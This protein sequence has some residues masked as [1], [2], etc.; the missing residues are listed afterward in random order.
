MALARFDEVLAEM[1]LA[2]DMESHN[3]SALALKGE[4]L[5]R[6][7]DVHQAQMILEQASKLVFGDPYVEQLQAEAAATAAAPR[8]ETLDIDPELEGVEIHDEAAM[9]AGMS[10]SHDSDSNIEL[11]D[12]DLLVEATPTPVPDN[13]DDDEQTIEAPAELMARLDAGYAGPI[14]GPFQDRSP[15]CNPSNAPSVDSQMWSSSATAARDSEAG[16]ARPASVGTL[17]P[18]DESG[19]SGL[20]LTS[21]PQGP[22]HSESGQPP[23]LGPDVPRAMTADMDLIREGLSPGQPVPRPTAAPRPVSMASAAPVE[24]RRDARPNPSAKRKRKV[25]A[26]LWIVLLLISVAG[27]FVAGLRLR[28]ERLAGQIRQAKQDAETFSAGDSYLGYRKARDLY[29]RIFK[30]QDDDPS[31]GALA[32]SEAALAAEFGHSPTTGAA[33]LTSV[34]DKEGLDALAASAYL[35]IANGNHNGASENAALLTQAFADE[36]VGHYLLGRAKI[37]SDDPEAA[38]VAIDK[39]LQLGASPLIYVAQARAE[40]QRG[41]YPEA[42]AAIAKASE[43]AQANAAA[44]IWQARIL[45]QSGELP[46]NPADPDDRLQELILRS[47]SRSLEANAL[48]PAQGAWAG[49]VLAEIKLQRGDNGEARKALAEAKIGRPT[50]WLFSEMLA[51]ILIRLGENKEAREEATRAREVWPQRSKPR[52]V[53]ALVALLDGNPE[54][55]IDELE[56]F[57]GIEASADALTVRGRAN[58][59]LGKLDAAV[60]DLDRALAMRSRDSDALIA[61]AKVDL[62]RGDAKAAI[63]R[64]E[65][66]YDRSAGPDLAIAYATALRTSGKSIEARKVLEPIAGEDGTVAALIELAALERS[67]GRFEEARA[68]FQRAISIDSGSLD[69][70]LG[71]ALLDIDDGRVKSGRESLDALVAEGTENGLILVEAARARIW[72]GDSEAATELLDRTAKSSSWLNWKVA[73][74]RGR[75]LLRHQEPI[76]AISELQRAQSLRPTD[77]EARILLMEA[78]FAARNR[79]GSGRALQD[80]TKTF[81]ES[82]LR[83]MASGIHALLHEKAADA[84]NSFS[85]ARSLLIDQKASRLELA[86]VAYWLGRSYE[87]SGDL[88]QASQWLQKATKLNRSHAGAYFWL[89]HIHHQDQKPKLMAASYEQA[90][91]IDPRHNPLAWFF[92]GTYYAEAGKKVAAVKAL[93]SFLRF[94]P[95]DSGDVVVEAKTLLGQIR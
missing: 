18:D 89:G 87:F 74:E 78:H 45:L 76:E 33:L 25:P 94:Y 35:A 86:R 6:K 28:E 12:E 91:A 42:L 13:L 32:R 80:I 73:R 48:S 79:Q 44:L 14:D 82:A 84:V 90:V 4:A 57:E 8:H 26:A 63:G 55:A 72:T 29:A 2:L 38:L 93:E 64:L 7:G 23:G 10:P 20:E 69:A 75:I 3:P 21:S 37:L 92:L 43:G 11:L 67:E 49:L 59:K 34:K 15:G 83:S 95:Q 1:K 53:L 31:R 47:R 54:G 9:H 56:N 50:D 27:G 62:L 16:F 77:V 68:V 70:R 36:P 39:A 40:A 24:P 85:E 41:H 71:A 81:R 58:L 17:F 65:P 5:L 30:I 19:V 46:E 66:M 60:T 61:R 52:I 51:D 22:A 88:R